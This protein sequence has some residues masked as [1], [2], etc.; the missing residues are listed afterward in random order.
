M[1]DQGLDQKL[2]QYYKERAPEYEDV[3]RGKFYIKV[4]DPSIY[5][6]DVASIQEKLPDYVNGHC[7]DIACGTGFWLPVYHKNCPAITLIDHS[8]E[9]LAQCRDKI[10]TL[11]IT[12]KTEVI[13][14]DLFSYPYKTH[15]YDTVFIGFLFSHLVETE[16]NRFIN[17]LKTVLK[18]TGRFVFIDNLWDDSRAQLR[19]SK[20]GLI[21]R[22]LQD[23][24][25]FE[26][27]KRYFDQPDLHTLAE[28]YRFDLDIVYWGKVFFLAAGTFK[29]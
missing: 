24:R 27:Y 28:Q 13:R 16:L 29:S 12:N 3:Y 9:V 5:P 4:A 23:G 2:L 17:I 21:K 19:K 11:G 26:I 10:N 1:E 6:H 15:A 14:A 22:Y 8:E 25:Q 20:A 18:T 7:L